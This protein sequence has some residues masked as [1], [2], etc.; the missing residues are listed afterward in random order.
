[1]NE[2]SMHKYARHNKDYKESLAVGCE[3]FQEASLAPLFPDSGK[4]DQIECG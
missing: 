1:V 2:I 3:A 4:H